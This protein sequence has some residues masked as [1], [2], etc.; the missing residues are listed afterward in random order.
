MDSCACGLYH[1]VVLLLFVSNLKIRKLARKRLRHFEETAEDTFLLQELQFCKFD[2]ESD[3]GGREFHA[4]YAVSH[5]TDP[6]AASARAAV[7]KAFWLGPVVKASFPFS[8]SSG[9]S[10]PKATN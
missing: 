9:R 10:R 7:Y 4:E 5:E 3:W 1:G 2:V 6:T 8:E